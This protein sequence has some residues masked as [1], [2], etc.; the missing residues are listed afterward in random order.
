MHSLWGQGLCFKSTHLFAFH[1]E[2][3]GR[4][5]I[6]IQVT[7]WL[8]ELKCNTDLC[9][10]GAQE[11]AHLAFPAPQFGQISWFLT[12]CRNVEVPLL[13]FLMLCHLESYRLFKLIPN[14]SNLW[15]LMGPYFSYENILPG[16]WVHCCFKPSVKAFQRDMTAELGPAPPAPVIP[17]WWAV[18]VGWSQEPWLTV[19]LVFDQGW[20]EGSGSVRVFLS[21]HFAKAP[22]QALMPPAEDM[23]S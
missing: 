11:R 9:T 17:M 7:P 6:G 4:G 15:I 16:P 12:I 22:Q 20:A 19:A 13:C 14:S 5:R 2:A 10:W 3:R 8:N 21:C 18:W 23:T 1:G